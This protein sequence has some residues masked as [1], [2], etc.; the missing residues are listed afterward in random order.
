MDPESTAAM[1]D[2]LRKINMI[3]E[4]QIPEPITKKPIENIQTDDKGFMKNILE[5]FYNA[6]QETTKQL[7]EDAHTDP[8][9]K[10]ALSTKKIDN[11]VII[12]GYTIKTRVNESSGKITYYDVMNPMG[13]KIATDLVLY[14]AALLLTKMLNKGEPI[15]GANIKRLL[16]LEET[17]FSNR[18]DA[19]RFK[20]KAQKAYNSKQGSQG[21]IFESRYQH[22]RQSAL[23]AKAEVNQ[24]A[25]LYR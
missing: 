16:Q 20:S 17:Y 24:L 14:E 12:N 6:S 3:E 7:V 11:G 8:E 23:Q 13:T 15:N 2:I 10:D 19:S 18:V 25:K 9:I 22:A 4:G 5:R 21:E 1:A